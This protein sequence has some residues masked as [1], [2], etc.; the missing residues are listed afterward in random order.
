M[1][2]FL[3]FGSLLIATFCRSADIGTKALA[4][5]RRVRRSALD[6]LFS[7]GR[8]DMVPVLTHLSIGWKAKG[9]GL[10]SIGGYS[11]WNVSK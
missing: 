9:S 6:I 5:N 4:Y 1:Y 10:L 2:S 7:A 11:T 3:S 8:S